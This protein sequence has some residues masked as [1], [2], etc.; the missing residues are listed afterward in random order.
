MTNLA[1]VPA[2]RYFNDICGM[3]VTM[4]HNIQLLPVTFHNVISSHFIGRK[5]IADCE[6]IKRFFVA[7]LIDSDI[8]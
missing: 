4:K 3:F 7:L 2:F 1:T 5:F 8:K 6:T